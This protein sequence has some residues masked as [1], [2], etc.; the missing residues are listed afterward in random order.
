MKIL[1]DTADVIQIKNMLHYFPIDGVTTNPSILAREAN[2]VK[3]T[4]LSI[5]ELLGADRMLFAQATAHDSAEIVSQ[6][7]AMTKLLG[8]EF[9]TK[10]PITTQGLRAVKMCREQG[11][12]TLVTAIFTPMQALL[13]AKAGADYVA[14]YVDRLDNI[15]SD[16]ATVVGEIIELYKLHGYKTQVLAASFKNIQQIYR[17]AAVGAH[18]VTMDANLCEK[19]IFHPYTDRSLEDF[20]IDWRSKFGDKGIDELI[21]G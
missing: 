15:V 17:A 4:L 8:E 12:K 5:R 10:I 21:K 3:H 9:Y 16:G 20:D 14:P 18:G 6:A 19:L 7:T 1:L 13:A 2:D 11:L